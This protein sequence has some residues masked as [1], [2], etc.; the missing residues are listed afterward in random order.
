[1]GQ[2]KIDED[3][4]LSVVQYLI[5]E[6]SDEGDIRSYVKF[7]QKFDEALCLRIL[8]SITAALR[9]LHSEKIAHQDL[10]ASNILFFKDGHYKLTDLGR[11]YDHENQAPH[12]FLDCAGDKTYAPPELLYGYYI[13]SD[14][15]DWNKRRL[16]CDMYLLGSLV[17][18]FYL[19]GASMT[20]LILNCLEDEYHPRKYK[21]D[22]MGVI[23]Y[24]QKCFAQIIRDIQSRASDHSEEIG[25]IVKQMCNPNPEKRGHPIEI[26]RKHKSSGQYNQYNLERYISVFNKLLKKTEN[27]LSKMG[28]K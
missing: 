17:A 26:R 2:I 18:S 12:D 4:P 3:K 6:L 10:K 11:A 20:H 1:M 28:N 23:T 14:D 13:D 5:L 21:G 24:V 7:E 8:H 25:N 16:G 22:Y 27:S 19:G 15:S 9:Q